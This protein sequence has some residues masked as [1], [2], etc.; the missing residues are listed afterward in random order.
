LQD[1]AGGS[2]HKFQGTAFVYF[3][4]ASYIVQLQPNTAL[5]CSVKTQNPTLPHS[6]DPKCAIKSTHDLKDNYSYNF[7]QEMS[8][9]DGERQR[10][11]VHS[12]QAVAFTPPL[13]PWR[14]P[15]CEAPQTR[16]FA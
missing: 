1:I 10:L 13:P 15:A 3:P 5:R 16:Q 9:V 2:S 6:F 4:K 8:D 14:I 11:P 7:D 12:R